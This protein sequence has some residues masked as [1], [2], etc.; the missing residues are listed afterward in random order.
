[1]PWV[2]KKRESSRFLPA[3]SR[4]A[5]RRPQAN[6]AK[7]RSP[8]SFQLRKYQKAPPLHVLVGNPEQAQR[9]N[10]HTAECPQRTRLNTFHNRACCSLAFLVTSSISPYDAL[11]EIERVAAVRL[12]LLP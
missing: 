3:V 11:G 6:V 12:P 7:L 2:P 9:G 4:Q 1:M 10:L 8:P 5:A